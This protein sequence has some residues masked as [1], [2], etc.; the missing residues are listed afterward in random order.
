M[1]FPDIIQPQCK[2][3]FSPGFLVGEKNY[4]ATIS[5]LFLLITETTKLSDTYTETILVYS[6]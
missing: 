3:W 4:L 5:R 1:R 6:M 2:Q